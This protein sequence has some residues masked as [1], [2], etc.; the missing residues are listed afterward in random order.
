MMNNNNIQ[1]FVIIQ[2]DEGYMVQNRITGEYLKDYK[3][4][5]CFKSISTAED[6]LE[7]QLYVK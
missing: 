5:I 2:T 7:A 6:L 3:G 4:D 1:S